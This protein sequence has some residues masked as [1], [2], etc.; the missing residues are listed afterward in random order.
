[1]SKFSNTKHSSYNFQTCCLSFSL[2]LSGETN[3][4][5]QKTQEKTTPPGLFFQGEGKGRDRVFG[6]IIRRL[7][8]L[9]AFGIRLGFCFVPTLALQWLSASPP[10]S[11]SLF[12]SLSLSLSLSFSLSLSGPPWFSPLFRTA[13]GTGGRQDQGKFYLQ[14]ETPLRTRQEEDCRT[15]A[16]DAI[17]A[18]SNASPLPR[19]ISVSLSDFVVC[20]TNPLE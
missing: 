13:K 7:C 16:G 8:L 2:F 3:S 11:L 14:R 5:V 1:M 15:R 19:F 6:F 12:L 10:L 20:S 18:L 17:D 9:F 4:A